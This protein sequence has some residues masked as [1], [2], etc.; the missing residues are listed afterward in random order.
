MQLHWYSKRV[1]QL[2]GFPVLSRLLCA[3]LLPPC[4]HWHNQSNFISHGGNLPFFSSSQGIPQRQWFGQWF[5][6]KHLLSQLSSFREEINCFS[7]LNEWQRASVLITVAHDCTEIKSISAAMSHILL[8]STILQFNP[9]DWC[10][11]LCTR[12]YS[13]IK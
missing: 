2:S 7:H 11:S 10:Q 4:S 12:S 3:H 6:Q 8:P 1:S 13:D 9:V 5:G